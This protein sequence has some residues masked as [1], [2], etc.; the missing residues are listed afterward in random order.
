MS[1]NT[2]IQL[3]ELWAKRIPYDSLTQEQMLLLEMEVFNGCGG[4][5]GLSFDTV[6]EKV[7][8]LDIFNE[9]KFSKFRHNLREQ[10]NR[11]DYAFWIGGGIISFV[12]ANFVLSCWIFSNLWWAGWK[13]RTA[14]GIASLL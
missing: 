2:I 10:C 7:S 9:D 11:H 6:L 5:G 1:P 14:L 12:R 13:I 8:D 3:S 4:Q